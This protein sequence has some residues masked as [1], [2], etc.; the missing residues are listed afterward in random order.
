LGNVF[1]Y[2][3]AG[4]KTGRSLLIDDGVLLWIVANA[5]NDASPIWH[6]IE[7]ALCHLAQHEVNAKDLVA[8]GALWELVCISWE[9]SQEDIHYLA[10]CTLNTSGTFQSELKQLHLV[11]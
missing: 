6:Y 5:N 10:Q 11:Y 2:Q 7:L 1:G 4:Y 3:V 8:V 9:C